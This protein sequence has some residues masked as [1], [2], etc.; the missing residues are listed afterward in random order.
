MGV[1]S[2]GV[3]NQIQNKWVHD[4]QDPKIPHFRKLNISNKPFF[5]FG[6]GATLW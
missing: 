5:E 4:K 1:N 3:R 6:G 2:E